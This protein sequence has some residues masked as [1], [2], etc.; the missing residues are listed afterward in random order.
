MDR[1][2]AWAMRLP[3]PCLRCGELVTVLDDWHIGH[4]IPRSVAPELTWDEDNT[5]PEHA[6][7]NLAAGA[8]T[9]VAPRV[10]RR[11]W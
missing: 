10:V 7:C 6:A 4:R 2:Q 5:W 1:R 8:T 9:P 3:L 11:A